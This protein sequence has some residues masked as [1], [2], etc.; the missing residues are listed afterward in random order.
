MT[1][2]NAATNAQDAFVKKTIDTLSDLPNV[3]WELAEE[4]PG[5]GSFFTNSSGYG[6]ASS[7]Q[8]WAPHMVGLIKAY[9][10][11]GTWEGTTYPGKPYKHPVGIGSMSSQDPDDQAL[12]SSTVDWIAPTISSN[13]ANQAPGIVSTNNQ[14]KVVIND[15]DHSFDSATL[16][17]PDGTVNDTKLR[18]YLWENFTS[19]A[20]GVL[21]MDPY[22]I[23]LPG[24]NPVRNT[25]SSPLNGVCTSGLD[26]KYEPFRTELGYLQSVASHLALINMTPQ[27]TL[28]STGFALASTVPTAA[29]YL[30][31]A[32]NGGT[33]DVDA[34]V[35][36]DLLNVVWIDPSTGSSSLAG[37]VQGGMVL[38][39]TSPFNGD[40]VLY[41]VD[42]AGHNGNPLTD[43]APPSIP[44]GLMA[45]G[46]SASEIDLSWNASTD[47][48]GVAG[49]VIYRNGLPIATAATTS[50]Q[51]IGLGAST[52]YSYT[53]SAF[54][55]AGNRSE[56]SIGAA[57]ATLTPGVG[58]NGLPT[59][60]G[61]YPLPNTTMQAVCPP[62][63]FGGSA[64]TSTTLAMEWSMPG[65]EE[66]RIPCGTASSFGAEA[67]RIMKA[68]R[69]I[70]WT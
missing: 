26:T 40:A 51:D 7:M 6:G 1:T 41:L 21:F 63:G 32:P 43:I 59:S 62:N 65:E 30:V 10:G 46:V 70:L 50:Y 3:V 47:D 60:P 52:S 9:E 14:S 36:T 67:T 69:S 35:T 22:D 16:L 48:V 54:D 28:S 66:W 53:V 11:G 39:F 57:A 18:N 5:N 56:Q 19:G 12:Y 23:Y 58:G 17:N 29:E 8:F 20:A 33:F 42:V 45:A 38:S 34:S 55:A 13:W 15:T 37:T 24:T 27:G 64:T 25:C 49:Y 61:W 2:N 31:Y 44:T 4:Q 68:T